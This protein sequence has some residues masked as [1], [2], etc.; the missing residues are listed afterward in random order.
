MAKSA[1]DNVIDTR[2]FQWAR[3]GQWFGLAAL[4]S[5]M[6]LGGFTDIRQTPAGIAFVAIIGMLGLMSLIPARFILTVYLMRREQR[7][8]HGRRVASAR[9]SSQR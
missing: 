3:W 1:L 9:K 7:S 8:H 4:L 2:W 5:A 6:L